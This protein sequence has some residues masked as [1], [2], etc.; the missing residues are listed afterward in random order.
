MTNPLEALTSLPKAERDEAISKMVAGPELDALMGFMGGRQ[1]ESNG[2][3]I[4]HNGNFLPFGWPKYTT[5]PA[6]FEGLRA[7]VLGE[8]RK[9]YNRID[10]EFSDYGKEDTGRLEL[11]IACISIDDSNAQMLI[12]DEQK[13]WEEVVSGEHEDHGPHLERVLFC[14]AFAEYWCD[15]H[16]PN[17]ETLEDRSRKHSEKLIKELRDADKIDPDKLRE[18]VTPLPA[19][20][21][22]DGLSGLDQF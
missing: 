7:F 16:Q 22:D 11:Q 4:D 10:I 12:I 8:M 2:D 14:Q 17:T 6:A 20:E 21:A 1:D 15:T 5:D 19:P 9:R 13:E 3:L 18:R